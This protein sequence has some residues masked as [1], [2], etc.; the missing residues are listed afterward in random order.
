MK[1]WIP[2]T[3]C[4]FMLFGCSQ[5]TATN[6]T[7][8]VQDAVENTGA[9]S[10]MDEIASRWLDTGADVPSLIGGMGE[11]AKEDAAGAVDKE[12]A[13]SL[14]LPESAFD[15]AKSAASLSNALMANLFTAVLLNYE[16]E[17]DV[18]KA[19]T[20]IV[21]SLKDAHWICAIPE[22]VRILYEN[23]ML[24]FEFGSSDVLDSFEEAVK[25]VLPAMEVLHSQDVE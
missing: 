13:S 10:I 25:G 20:E 19:E 5:N 8:P 24:L 11:T 15:G 18:F 12:D 16:N 4:G 17:E 1:K 22:Q 21:D 3:L 7:D 14:M 9:L 6:T 2:L 23:N